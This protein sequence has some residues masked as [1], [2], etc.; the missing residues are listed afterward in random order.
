M[1]AQTDPWRWHV[2]EDAETGDCSCDGC[3]DARPGAW[4]PDHRVADR[5]E[6]VTRLRAAGLSYRQITEQTGITAP[7]RYQ[8]QEAWDSFADGIAE[9]KRAYREAN[10][11]EIAEKKRAYYEAKRSNECV[12]CAAPTAGK[13]CRTCHGRFIGSRK[14]T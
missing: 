1:S 8:S 4:E 13:R 12:D 7:W 10:R 3:L 5:I 11:E 6:T 2:P 14:R 9:K